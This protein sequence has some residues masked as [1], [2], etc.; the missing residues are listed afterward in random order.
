MH[1]QPGRSCCWGVR[2]CVGLNHRWITE[3]SPPVHIHQ[4]AIRPYLT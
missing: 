2:G 1:H 4:E 3:R